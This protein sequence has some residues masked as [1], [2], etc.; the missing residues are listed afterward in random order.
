MNEKIGTQIG[1]TLGVVRACDVDEDGYR[2]AKVLRIYEEM[3][4]DK[5]I[6]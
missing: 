1:K 6:S 5:P 4:L 3:D 2:W